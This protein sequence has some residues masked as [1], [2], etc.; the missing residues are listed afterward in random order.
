MKVGMI[1]LGP[2]GR[3]IAKNVLR[4]FESITIP[5][6]RAKDAVEELRSLGASVTSIEGVVDHSSHVLLCLSNGNQV[7]AILNE[8]LSRWK[9][10]Q[11]VID[12][13]TLSKQESLHNRAF[14]KELGVDYI[15]APVIRGPKEAQ[16]GTLVTLLGLVDQF[17]N[18]RV[19]KIVSSYSETIHYFGS[20]S[21]ALVAKLLNNY[22]T[23]VTATVLVDVIE[24]ARK[25]HVDLH[26]MTEILMSSAARSGT[27]EKMVIPIL[28]EDYKGHL[29]SVDNAIKDLVLVSQ[30][31]GEQ[32]S[33]L[34]SAAASKLSLREHS[35]E[36]VLSELL[37]PIG[38]YS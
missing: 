13:T 29:F 5:E 15:D 27:L 16:T 10:D 3:G 14:L 6:H 20:E 7:N 9:T 32:D 19:K 31:V 8:N 37:K 18:P 34:A 17:Q 28:G 2:M 35:N 22:V 24:A 11:V 36:T 4:E 33:D 38:E 26:K 23:C 12:V 1:G 30:I 21:N 25:N